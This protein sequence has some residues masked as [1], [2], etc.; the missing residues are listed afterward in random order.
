[1]AEP[2][3]I[4]ISAKLSIEAMQHVQ[5]EFCRDPVSVVIGS[6]QGRLIFHH[7]YPQQQRITGLQLA[8]QIAKNRPRLFGCEVSDA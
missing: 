8:A 7:V 2:R 3:E 6:H 5:V 1:M 4:K